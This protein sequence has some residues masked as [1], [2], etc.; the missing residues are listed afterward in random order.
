MGCKHNCIY[1][2]YICDYNYNIET[3][4]NIISRSCIEWGSRNI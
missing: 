4:N 1:K 2:I 3:I